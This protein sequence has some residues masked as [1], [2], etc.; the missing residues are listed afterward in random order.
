M[1]W[2]AGQQRGISGR[3]DGVCTALHTVTITEQR[4]QS[5]LALIAHHGAAPSSGKV[6]V[7][8]CPVFPYLI[9]QFCQASNFV[10]LPKNYRLDCCCF[11][12]TH[13]KI[14]FCV[15][16]TIF[17]TTNWLILDN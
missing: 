9:S 3:L 8:F 15:K 6:M 17:I 16:F 1:L 10:P 14:T 11:F 4:Q 13:V 5:C 2:K 7:L 12:H